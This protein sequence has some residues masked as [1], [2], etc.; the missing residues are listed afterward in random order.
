MPGSTSPAIPRPPR[1]SWQKPWVV[2]IVAASKS[3]S[4]RGEP[5]RPRR[6]PRARAGRRGGR[7]TSSSA[8]AGSPASTRSRPCSALTSRSRTRSRSSPVA[9]RVKVTSR[10]SSSGDALGDVA[11]GERG[12]RVRLAGAGAR[13]EHGDAGRAAGRRRRTAALGR[14]AHRSCAPRRPRSA[15]PQAAGERPKRVGSASSQPGPSSSARGGVGEQV[16]ERQLAAEG[17][18]GARARR[19]RCRSDP[20]SHSSRAA[21]SASPPVAAARVGA[22]VLQASGSGSRSPRS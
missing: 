11:G 15:G 13:L 20:G 17:E 1:T 2:A 5:A 10:S 19:P 8:S 21:R 4:A 14:R 7:A 12:D 6:G 3:A 18:H 9:M 22:D 16:V